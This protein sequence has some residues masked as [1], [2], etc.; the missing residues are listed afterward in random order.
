VVDRVSPSGLSINVVKS[1]QPK[2]LT[3]D[4]ERLGSWLEGVFQAAPSWAIPTIGGQ[5]EPNIR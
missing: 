4:A 1:D 5:K 2:T 3:K